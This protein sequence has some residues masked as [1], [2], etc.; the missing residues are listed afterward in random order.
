MQTQTVVKPSKSK[1]AKAAK[2]KPEVKA[3]E[4]PVTHYGS[5]LLDALQGVYGVKIQG[6]YVSALA[7]HGKKQTVFP[8]PGNAIYALMKPEEIKPWLTARTVTSIPPGDKVGQRLFDQMMVEFSKLSKEAKEA[9][10]AAEVKAAKTA[11]E[12][13]PKTS[14]P[15]PEELKPV[16]KAETPEAQPP[17]AE[18][19][20]P[21][22]EAAPAK[23]KRQRKVKAETV[24]KAAATVEPKVVEVTQA[25]V[26]R[27]KGALRG[28]NMQPAPRGPNTK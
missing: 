5:A 7:Y 10:A 13:A 14:A 19:L 16:A 6:Y 2:V 25:L 11:K 21:V 22:L 17:A 20:K 9:K 24:V 15:P 28:T 27:L 3:E 12:P 4:K 8:R 23:A 18:E 1:A 26:D